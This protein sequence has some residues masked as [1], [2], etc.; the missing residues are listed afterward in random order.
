MIAAAP[1]LRLDAVSITHDNRL[2]SPVYLVVEAGA[3][4]GVISADPQAAAALVAAVAGTTTIRSGHIAVD[5]RPVTALPA[6]RR[7]QLGIVAASHRTG[8]LTVEQTM[9]LAVQRRTQ[10]VRR[11]GQISVADSRVIRVSAALAQTGLTP[12]AHARPAHLPTLQKRL[13]ALAVAL[14]YRPRLL[15]V[16]NLAAGL[17]T[18]ERDHLTAVLHRLPR[19]LATLVAGP[20]ATWIEAV[21]DTV[22]HLHP[23]P[24]TAAWPGATAIPGPRRPAPGA[25]GIP[26]AGSWDV[27]L[28]SLAHVTASTDTAAITD[29]RLT[30]A[31]GGVH[32]VLGGPGSGK[33]LLLN[34]IAGRHT[35]SRSALICWDGAKVRTGDPGHADQHGISLATPDQLT[36]RRTVGEHLAYAERHHV[37][38]SAPRWT[39]PAVLGVFPQLNRLGSCYEHQLA[40]ADRIML[41]IGVALL[42]HPRL[43]LLDDPGRHLAAPDR[44]DLAA[45]LTTIARRGV[46]ILLAETEPALAFAVAT[47]ISVLHGGAIVFDVPTAAAARSASPRS[48]RAA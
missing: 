32:A 48:A 42:S 31:A 4:H 19:A 22:T 39:I 15:L 7:A 12:H 47:Q 9:H 27:P 36:A 44:A 11:A 30:V 16:D 45:A 13:L 34:V 46:T 43:L 6:V 1:L 40:A 23:G 41:G 24:L 3:R 28:L 35:P 14:V 25:A 10:I 2:L 21:T 38:E 17:D 18:A 20:D 8:H 5:G 37:P 29:L 33:T 26:A